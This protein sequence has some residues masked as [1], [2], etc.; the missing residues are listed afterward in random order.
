VVA[1]TCNLST[2]EAVVWELSLGPACL[3]GSRGIALLL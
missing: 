3:S 1:W 2:G